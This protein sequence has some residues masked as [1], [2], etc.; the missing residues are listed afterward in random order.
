MSGSHTSTAGD[1]VRTC[2]QALRREL[3]TDK[4]ELDLAARTDDVL[5]ACFVVL[6]PLTAGGTGPD[7][8]T[9][10]DALHLREV[11]GLAVLQKLEV[12]V[13]AAFVLA[14]VRAR[15]S[16]FPRL[17]TLPAEIEN[18]LLVCCANCALHTE[19]NQVLSLHIRFAPRTLLERT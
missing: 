15:S 16:T 14:A 12:M 2:F 19:V 1:E 17:Q 7:G 8:G 4:A 18:F 10:K 9:R 13:D 11:G 6:H 5:A 3:Q